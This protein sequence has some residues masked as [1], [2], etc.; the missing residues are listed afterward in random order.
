MERRRF[1]GGERAV[2]ERRVDRDFATESLKLPMVRADT[3]NQGSMNGSKGPG[4]FPLLLESH[5]EATEY[6][7]TDNEPQSCS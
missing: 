6:P 1:S 5:L 7:F 4:V 2:R 3:Q